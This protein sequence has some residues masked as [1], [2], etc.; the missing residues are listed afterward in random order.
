MAKSD[1]NLFRAAGGERAKATKRSPVSIML[2]VGL[3]LIVA[4]L[5]VAAYFNIK[6]NSA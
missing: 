6:V 1:I 5:G 3:V 2:I 4:A